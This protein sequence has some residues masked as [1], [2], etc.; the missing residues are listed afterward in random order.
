L[1]Y[2]I[3]KFLRKTK[4]AEMKFLDANGLGDRNGLD[5]FSLLPK[6]VDEWYELLEW[7]TECLIFGTP[8]EMM[9]RSHSPHTVSVTQIAMHDSGF[10]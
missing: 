6:I 1:S 8:V 3:V 7:S 4:I 10:V 5:K 9:E 2:G